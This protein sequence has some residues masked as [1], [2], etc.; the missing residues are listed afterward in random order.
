MDKSQCQASRKPQHEEKCSKDPCP[1]AAWAT[2]AWGEVGHPDHS[3]MLHLIAGKY[4]RY[5]PIIPDITLILIKLAST[6]CISH[7]TSF[8]YICS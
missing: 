3:H 2:G 4:Q 8:I 6:L 7:I 1:D 5:I